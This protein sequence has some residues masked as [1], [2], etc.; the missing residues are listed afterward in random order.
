[1]DT[2]LRVDLEAAVNAAT[3]D[4]LKIKQAIPVGGGCI[5]EALR[6]SGDAQS[7]FVKLNQAREL[8]MFEAEFESLEVIA[9]TKSIRAPAPIAVGK[10]MDKSWLMLEDMEMGYA[11]DDKLLGQNLAE[12]HL[13]GGKS[14]GWTADNFIGTT[15]QPNTRTQDWVMFWSECR[16]G[17]QLELAAR[18]GFSRRA[19]VKGHQLQQRLGVFFENYQ[20][21]PALLHGDLWSGN[22]SGGPEGRP[23]I[24]DP[25]SYYGDHE[26]DLAMMT[27]FGSPSAL[28]F[29]AYKAV[30]PIDSG[31]ARRALLYNLYHVLNHFNLFG[32]GY[33]RQAES[34]IDRLLSD[35]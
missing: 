3:G 13:H 10:T 9:A 31:Y 30:F 14:F 19:V 24:F 33:G 26:S 17:Y 25:A 6:V 23:V 16:L 22:W 18:S 35:I 34:M 11:C 4:E 1:M 28:F 15:A 2:R 5:N 29:D 27:L 32:G 12:M 8:P 20:P 21:L 7:Y